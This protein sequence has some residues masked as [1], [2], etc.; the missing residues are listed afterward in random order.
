MTV[1]AGDIGGTNTR[2]ALFGDGS[3]EPI[4]E[5]TYPS[6]AHGGLDIIAEKFLT[7]TRTLGAGAGPPPDRACFGIA[8]PVEGN[9]CRATNLPWVVDGRVL[10]QRLGISKVRLV[11]DFY[12]A[13][14]GSIVVPASSLVP[15]G[16]GPRDPKGPIAVLGA[17]TGLGQAF[18]L[19]SSTEARYQVIPSEGGHVDFAPRTP[20]EADLLRYLT[21]KYGRVSYER[22]LSGHGLVDAYSFLREEPAFKTLGRPETQAALAT[23]DPAAVISQHALDGSD[24]VCGAALAIFCG[25]LGA[26]AGNLAL[27]VLASGGVFVAGGIAPRVLPFLQRGLFRDAFERK[28]RLQPLV[29]RIP[30]FVVTHAQPGLLGAAAVA[31]S[32]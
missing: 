6:A 15:L 4:A 14:L 20:L 11:N 7:E 24:P 8:G 18:L 16:G 31:R 10:S 3:D 19:W 2:L 25:V 27:T 29:A 17:G 28:G 22:I 23:D 30:A 32:L 21:A 1:L 9:V 13:A 12:A 26:L 5:R